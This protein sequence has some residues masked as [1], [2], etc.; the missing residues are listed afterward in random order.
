[1]NQAG[2]AINGGAKAKTV[3]YSR[4]NRYGELEKRYLM[5]AMDEG[6]LMC[7]RGSMVPRFEVAAAQRFGASHA[8]MTTSGTT[9]IQ[10]AL[11]ACGVEEG[12]EVV[13]TAVAD[14]GTFMSILMLHAVPVFADLSPDTVSAAPAAVEAVI[15]PR[16]KAVLVV[17]MAGIVADM[18]AFLEIGE[19]HDV[20]IVEDCSQAHG[21]TWRGQCVGTLGRIGAFSM[22]ESK[23]MS[24]GDG[25]FMLTDDDETARVARLFIDKAYVRGATQRGEEMMWFAATNSR[26]NC[27]SAAIALAQLERLD[28]NIAR[29]AQIAGRY[30]AELA[31]LPGLR[32][33]TI[34]AHS[35]P[36]WWPVPVLYTG[37]DPN[38][39]ELLRVL[40]AE[41]LGINGALSPARGNLHTPVIRDRRFYPYST[42]LPHFLEGISFDEGA[43]PVADRISSQILRLPMD[44]RFTDLDVEETICG[45]RKV[46][47]AVVSNS[48]RKSG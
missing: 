34:P 8:I 26:P 10:T 1:M 9:A 36:A 13:T 7:T 17:H 28:E 15:T 21:A 39:D 29:R 23:H 19:K 27:Q 14:A 31:D 22:N 48:W 46:W 38:R 44:H 12:D 35:Q 43:C 33:P 24:C 5:E 47:G 40:Q 2:L 30:Y 20:A 41:G 4:P 32:F 42:H 45:I 11:A 25:G 18:D 3:P 16:T 6:I 37:K